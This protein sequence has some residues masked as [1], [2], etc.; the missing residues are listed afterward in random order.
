MFVIFGQFLVI[1][2]TLIIRVK[3]FGKM[4]QLLTCKSLFKIVFHKNF[5]FGNQ[6]TKCLLL[7]SQQSALS[8]KKQQKKQHLNSFDYCL[9]FLISRSPCVYVVTDVLDI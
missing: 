3:T 5:L 1:K 2:I 6:F 9:C 4:I 8:R 7:I